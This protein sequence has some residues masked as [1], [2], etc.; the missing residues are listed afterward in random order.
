MSSPLVPLAQE[1]HD[2]QTGLVAGEERRP[3]T[4]SIDSAAPSPGFLPSP[5]PSIGASAYEIEIPVD[6]QD[7]GGPA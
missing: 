4:G 6:R 5:S 2:L 7:S 1:H 3:V